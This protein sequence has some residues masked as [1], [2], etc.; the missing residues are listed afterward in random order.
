MNTSLFLLLLL[1]LLSA[2]GNNN[3]DKQTYPPDSPQAIGSS[4]A[5][6]VCL[7]YYDMVE[8][9][10]VSQT[11]SFADMPPDQRT[12]YQANI[13]SLS[14]QARQCFASAKQQYGITDK[15]EKWSAEQKALL[16]DILAAELQN[17]CPNVAKLLDGKPFY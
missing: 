10:R 14:Q 7:C 11:S 2:C 8:A 9:V 12:A 4:L 1:I 17:Q 5:H 6:N 13:D 3:T 15:K 16:E